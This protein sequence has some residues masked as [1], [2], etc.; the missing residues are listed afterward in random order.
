MARSGMESECL[1][2]INAYSLYQEIR[3]EPENPAIIAA[4]TYGK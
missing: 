3:K 4:S 2:I 1:L